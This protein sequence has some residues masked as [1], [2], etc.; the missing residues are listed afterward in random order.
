MELRDNLFFAFDLSKL[1][2]DEKKDFCEFLSDF[3]SQWKGN[4]FCDVK[5]DEVFLLPHPEHLIEFQS[6][7]IAYDDDEYENYEEFITKRYAD[8]A[9]E[10]NRRSKLYTLNNQYKFADFIKSVLEKYLSIKVWGHYVYGNDA[11]AWCP[12]FDGSIGYDW[13]DNFEELHDFEKFSEWYAELFEEFAG[14]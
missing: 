4:V 1:S 5:E 3:A 10:R 12:D 14:Y 7:N 11:I 9:T 8:V 13:V 2:D 6:W